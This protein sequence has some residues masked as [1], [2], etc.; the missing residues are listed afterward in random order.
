MKHYSTYKGKRTKYQQKKNNQFKASFIILV[1]SAG[2]LNAVFH[3]A[4]KIA[5]IIETKEIAR[6]NPNIIIEKVKTQ[7]FDKEVTIRLA[8][9]QACERKGLGDQCVE[10][11]TS[12]AYQESKFDFKARGD[13]G[14][15]IGAFQIHLGYHPEIKI[16]QAE[17]PYWAA[18]WTIKRLLANGYPKYRSISIMKH[19]GTPGTKTTLEYLRKI[20]LL[21][22]K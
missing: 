5:A 8:A 18:D 12:M 19:N 3:P 2:I 9:R 13:S 11:L 1:I 15:A 22:L 7:Y 16:E 4:Q 20:N 6:E 10:D 17:D 21:A 14:K